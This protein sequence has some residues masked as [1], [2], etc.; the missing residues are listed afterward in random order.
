MNPFA[1]VSELRQ[2]LDAKEFSA[3]E[4]TQFYLDR[5]NQFNPELNCL[6]TI[7]E[8]GA[9]QAAQEADRR[10]QRGEVGPLTGI[11][12][13]HKDVFCTK[14]LR[15]TCASKMLANFVAP[16]D[17]TVVRRLRQAG[18]VLIGKANMDEFAMG[19]SNETS[20]FGP[21]RNPWDLTRSP[22][23]SSGGSACAVAAGCVPLATGTDTG[24]SIRQPS[25]CC[26]ITG[27]KPT[28]GRVSRFGM[29]AF[30]SSL[31]QAGP[32]AQ[33]AEDAGLLLSTMEGQDPQ[34]STSAEIKATVL[35]DQDRT[36]KIGM[37]NRMFSDLDSNL[38]SSLEQAKREFEA[39][40]WSIVEVELAHLEAAIAAYYVISGAEASANLARFDGVRY[41]YRAQSP[42]D[43]MDLYRRSR[44]EGF[45]KEVKRRILTGTYALSVGYYDA[46]YKQAQKIRR[47]VQTDFLEALREVDL[48]FAPATPS[49]AF[50]I[51]SLNENPVQMYQQDTYT[52]PV[53][54]AGLPSLTLPCGF[55]DGLPMGYQLIG[56]AFDEAT[57]LW[58]G[59]EYQ[60]RTDWHHQPP[61][62]DEQIENQS[63]TVG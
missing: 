3:R 37:A 20:Y 40:G 7:D 54:L 16:Y 35:Q 41:G 56:R 25:A 17:A 60:K 14:G 48:I 49:V 39:L 1:S 9:L 57:V 15:T 31:D 4:L 55:V 59:R 62:L 27:L 38:A 21:V 2:Q 58:A 11:P 42:V 10:I 47:L 44:S 28:Y 22:G 34:D 19:S 45:G 5:T 32:L 46:Y 53:S 23:G 52:I 8:D 29:I 61:P 30:A 26:G 33:S 63:L 50:E 24:G 6:I 43:I 18:L 36:L 13:V 51:G 12:L